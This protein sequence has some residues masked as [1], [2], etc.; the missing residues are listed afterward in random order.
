MPKRKLR[1]RC[2]WMCQLRCLRRRTLRSM[3]RSSARSPS[4]H[5]ALAGR[6]VANF[7]LASNCTASAMTWD[8]TS[9]HRGKLLLHTR[10]RST[11]GGRRDRALSKREYSEAQVRRI[12][13]AH[14]PFLLPNDGIVVTRMALTGTKA[15]KKARSTSFTPSSFTQARCC[16][17]LC[18]TH[19]GCRS[20]AGRFCQQLLQSSPLCQWLRPVA[21]NCSDSFH[22]WQLRCHG[23]Q[24][25]HARSA[26]HAPDENVQA[27]TSS[28]T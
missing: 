14:D 17:V 19:S 12:C 7:K 28:G 5:Q 20:S 27:R 10:Q 15:L 13:T 21:H 2:L 6:R 23:F 24:C 9:T 25:L 11:Q 18:R 3:R 16:K 4:T 1:G 26:L 8:P 22:I